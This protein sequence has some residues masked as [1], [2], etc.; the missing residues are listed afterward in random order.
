MSSL[1]SG[2]RIRTPFVTPGGGVESS[3]S[4]PS[5]SVASHDSALI[6]FPPLPHRLLEQANEVLRWRRQ[7]RLYVAL[8]QA[9]PAAMVE[10]QAYLERLFRQWELEAERIEE[11]VVREKQLL[12]GRTAI[13]SET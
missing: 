9:C 2:L 12:W 6:H 13:A 8:F 3:W 5:H 4:S 1:S 7:L 11:D 10:H